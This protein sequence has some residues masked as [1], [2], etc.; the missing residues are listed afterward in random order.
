M[1]G[2]LE[3]L[4]VIDMGVAI[5]MPTAAVTLA[6]WGAD[7][8][9]LESPTAEIPRAPS[10]PGAA[11]YHGFG[12]LLHRN[13]R[14]IAIDLKKKLGQEILHKLVQR[15]DVFLGSY[16]QSA[17]KQLKADYDILSQINP[18]LIYCLLTGYGTKGPDKDERGYDYAAAWARGGAQYQMGE[19]GGI[20]PMNLEGFMDRVTASHIVGGVLAALRHK[21]KTGE[22]QELDISLY[23]VGVWTLAADI[24]SALL[25]APPPKF[26]RAKTGGQAH[27]PLWNSYRA[28]DGRWFQLATQA[29]LHWPEFC[30]AIERP[31][32]ENDPRFGGG[33]MD[34]LRQNSEELISIL[35]EIFATK[36][37]E[38]WEKPFREN[39]VI[40]GLVQSPMEV[41]QDP[42]ALA[43]DFFAELDN[44]ELGKIKVVT[45]PMKFR[46]NPASVR[47]AAPERGQNTEEILLDLGYSWED[48][49]R[50]KE[51]EVI[52]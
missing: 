38:E 22:G 9:R 8:I 48:I 29:G 17:L 6:E 44:P 41:T 49:S 27:N 1:A 45:M 14:H 32:L 50:F 4:K 10:I 7:V 23:H 25:G 28:K 5:A 39:N 47:T 52:L 30:R 42:Q 51:Q 24:Q 16:E 3:G 43:N 21:D 37:R 36:T 19:P 31:D 34:V 15:A 12:D 26:E 40:Y 18:G 46:Q 35:D 2:V 33:N 11:I 20:P 13:K